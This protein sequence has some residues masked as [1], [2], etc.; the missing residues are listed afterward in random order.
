[1]AVGRG[2]LAAGNRALLEVLD[3]DENPSLGS[4][5]DERLLSLDLSPTFSNPFGNRKRAEMLESPKPFPTTFKLLDQKLPTDADP[6][7]TRSYP[8]WI[9]LRFFHIL[10]GSSLVIL[11]ALVKRQEGVYP[12][13]GD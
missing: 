4:S 5:L 11:A 7:P 13:Q 12:W 3:G 2:E 6:S 8:F 9:L 10:Y 1:M